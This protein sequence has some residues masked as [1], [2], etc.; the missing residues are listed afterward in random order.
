MKNLI[1][2][3]FV[4][5]LITPIVS[6]ATIHGTVYDFS[7]NKIS[8]SIIEINTEPTQ[9]QIT[10]N[11][12]YEFTVNNGNYTITAKTIKNEL[13]TSENII[14][15]KEGDYN[16][17]LIGF[18]NVEEESIIINGSEIT[19]EANFEEESISN[20]RLVILS[21]IIF[22]ALFFALHQIKK[23]SKEETTEELDLSEKIL[24][25]I[26]KQEGRTT[27]K[28]LRKQ[29]PFSEAKISLILT[30][31]ESKN[32]IEKIKKGRSNVII[33]KNNH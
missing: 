11:G 5:A 17:D 28:E 22:I 29:F 18:I 24:N 16:I 13:I 3:I 27:Q 21:I 8:K 2:I 4:L 10:N 9:K 26:K 6:A 14:V 19:P 20:I 15:N 25:F 7:L 23:K 12:N 31:L 1:S 33:L 30:E 32:R